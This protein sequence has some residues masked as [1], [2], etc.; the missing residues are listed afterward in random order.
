M[1]HFLKGI[2]SICLFAFINNSFAQ[3]L[4]K[5]S[6]EPQRFAEE[7]NLIFNQDR[8]ADKKQKE[9]ASLIFNNFWN[10]R[11]LEAKNETIIIDIADFMLKNK[12][13]PF[14]DYLLYFNTLINITASN[15][16]E[17]SIDNW[18]LILQ[19]VVKN[20]SQKGFTS[21]LEK[22]NDLVTSN[23]IYKSNAVMWKTSN[24]DYSFSYDTV[25]C[26][27]FVATDLICYANKDSSIIFETKGTYYPLSDEWIGKGGKVNWER[28]GFDE[29]DVYALIKKYKVSLKFS[30]YTADSVTFYDRLYFDKPLF[31]IL[32]EKVMADVQEDRASYPRFQSYD[33]HLKM[34]NIFKDIDYEGGFALHGVKVLGTGDE[35]NK[36]KI[37]F[38]REGKRFI[39]TAA[40]S[41]TIRKDRLASDNSSV[42]IYWEGDSVYHPGLQMKY[43]DEKKEL[44]M[45]RQGDGLTQSPYFDTYHKIDMYVEALYWKLDEPKIELTMIKGPNA[46]GNALFES[47]N[48]FSENRFDMLQGIDEINPVFRVWNYIR[49]TKGREFTLNEFVNYVK[50]PY[51]QVKIMLLNLSNLGFLT[52]DIDYDK[53]FIKDRLFQFINAKNKKTD[54]D[55]I[56]F[57]SVISADNNATLSLLSFDLKLRGVAQVFL[58]SA[59][60]VFIYPDNQELILKKNRD[61][62]FS[63]RI[64]AGMFDFF[65][66][67]C[68]F[69]YDRFKLNLTTI[70]SLSFKVKGP[71]DNNGYTP[72]I[73]VRNVLQ[74]LTGDLFIDNPN[75]KSGTKAYPEF[76]IFNS[77]KDSYVY[78]DKKSIEKGAYKRDK[79]YFHVKPFVIDS[80]DDFTTENMQF[81]GYLASAGIFPD[82]E[83]PLKVMDDYSLGLHNTT[84]LSGY[85]AYGGKGTFIN[86]IHLN[87]NGLRGNGTLKYLTS[88]TLSNDFIFYPDSMNTL[89]Q[90]FVVQD[91]GGY[92]Q[93][94]DVVSEN[95]KIHWIPYQDLMIATKTKDPFAMYSNQAKLSGP[96]FLTPTMLTGTGVMDF[97]DAIMDSK[98]FKFKQKQ[99]DCDTANFKLKT[100]ALND[101]ALTTQN[102]QAHIDFEKRIGEFKSNGGGSIVCFPVN[103]YICYMD[104]FE[105]NMDKEEIA[106]QNKN[107]LKD[108]DALKNMS[109][110]ELADVELHGSEFISIHP[111]QDSIR[112]YSSKAKF[113]L[114][115][116]IIRAEDVKV[117]KIADA[118]IFPKD[119]LVTIYKKAQIETLKNSI[120][121]AN[122]TTKYHEIFNSTIDIFSS[123]KYNATGN[124]NYI[125]ENNKKQVIY[126]DKIS[127]DTTLQTYAIGNINDLANFTLSPYYDYTGN[128]N[129]TAND[130][131][132]HFNGAFRIKHNCD[133]II[134]LQWVKFKSFINPKDIYIP[135]EKNLKDINNLKM[136]SGIMYSNSNKI[137]PAFLK[138]KNFYSDSAL[139]SSYGYIYYDKDTDEYRISS[140][141]KLK[142]NDLSGDYISFKR[143]NCSVYGEGKIGL[144][145]SFGQLKM[146]NYG[147]VYNFPIIDSTSIETVMALD[148]FMNDDAMKTFSETLEGFSGLEAIDISE[149]NYYKA[150]SYFIGAQDADKLMAD[151]GLYGYFKKFPSELIH[152]IYLT[153]VIFKWD[154]NLKSYVSDGLI[155]IGSI[156]KTQ[157][158]KYVFGRL[159]I[160]KKRGGDV[161]NMY[162]EIDADEWY[163]FSYNKNLMQAISSNALFN[164]AIL[165]TK[166]DKRELK[167]KS[168]QSPYRYI[169][170]TERKKKDFLKKFG[171]KEEEDD[172]EDD[173]N[174][175]KKKNKEDE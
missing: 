149:D 113:N 54:Y 129:L 171:I 166:T 66:K 15:Q 131:F 135:I 109:I 10:N 138:R 99:Y 69:D 161:L 67:I 92:V 55:I 72:L 126:F 46:S 20:K 134:P 76:P 34:K 85:P 64:H 163:F 114:R 139:V 1:N 31:G 145:A 121:L 68:S 71:T 128:V 61:F 101:F 53:I 175:K 82:I 102:Y 148:F 42:T 167:T 105:W 18:L 7:V 91:Q 95:V 172:S 104:E 5:F 96:L 73:K 130:E 28:A 26:V 58:S 169:I 30:K 153:N 157:I 19:K 159:E 48:F 59:Q 22:S 25:P 40:K 146:E 147:K 2:I 35:K 160:V 164:K 56:Q 47:S 63:G 143:K 39:V 127:V 152:T 90:S 107:M 29:K 93:Y 8:N 120:I 106:L 75:N 110:Q 83:Q 17:K 9:E 86:D 37:V 32:S 16:T 118:A 112:F 88:T 119:G 165:E 49:K 44:S 115:E 80:L 98:L 162:F 133:S 50:L 52:Y 65:A 158:N 173:E 144:G 62:V 70:D 137:Y 150:L 122:T 11:S 100:Y 27:V 51:E 97:K 156:Y 111:A 74:D 36:A 78:Y 12:M 21:F 132:L 81:N 38:N 124:Y 45:L 84:S 123:N 33:K 108:N 41:Y 79:F 151:V 87:N 4:K 77:K 24:G 170:S 6:R 155:G 174:P 103:Q 13:K 168:G 14:P 154:N 94:P 43:I 136:F 23:C 3:D 125:D 142:Q 57:N 117:I 116:N 60:K 140:M 141:E 89:A